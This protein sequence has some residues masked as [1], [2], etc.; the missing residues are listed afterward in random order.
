[1]KRRLALTLALALIS[2]LAGAQTYT[3][4]TA[5]IQ[6][7]FGGVLAGGSFCAT[8]YSG[9]NPTTITPAGGS[10]STGPF[11]STISASGTVSSTNIPNLATASPSGLTYNV[12]AYDSV[13][14][15]VVTWYGL[16][17][18]NGAGPVNLTTY[19]VTF[20][21]QPNTWPSLAG[22]GV[23]YL[24]CTSGATY[25]QTNITSN[26]GW[27][28]QTAL[29]GY[30]QW[31]QEGSV[32]PAPGPG[33]TATIPV[34]AQMISD[35]IKGT[36]QVFTGV[37]TPTFTCAS[38][39][40]LYVQTDASPTGAA[41]WATLATSGTPTTNWVRQ[42]GSPP[43]VIPDIVAGFVLVNGLTGTN[44]GP[45]LIAPRTATIGQI[46]GTFK[47]A[48]PS[49]AFRY[50]ILINGTSITGGAGVVYNAGSTPGNVYV[51]P[52]ST[53]VSI[54]QNSTITINV[55]SGNANWT[56]FTIQAES[57]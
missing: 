23:P 2:A 7:G 48:D 53:P 45:I 42:I 35:A 26:N 44:V 31:M 14:S 46:V 24:P 56:N 5:T 12:V 4:V 28:C 15:S 47:A 34:V 22:V 39:P 41:V 16:T 25:T 11:C 32:S 27:A 21:T 43:A 29:A 37:G 40:C 51:T 13:G 54:T 50:D 8:P 20:S 18:I 17:N 1:M 19:S 9:I 36:A 30:T 33:L 38:S 6:N 55:T 57:N 10:P 3:P 49:V 52:L